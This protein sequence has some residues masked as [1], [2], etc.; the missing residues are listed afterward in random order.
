MTGEVIRIGKDLSVIVKVQDNGIVKMTKQLP[1]VSLQLDML[2]TV[3][4]I[5]V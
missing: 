3:K 5:H 4:I 1:K 2:V